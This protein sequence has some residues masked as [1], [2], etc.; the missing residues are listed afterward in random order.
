MLKKSESKRFIEGVRDWVEEILRWSFRML[1][2]TAPG[3]FGGD[4]DS[5]AVV[6]AIRKAMETL[7]KE[8]RSMMATILEDNGKSME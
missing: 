3:E 7:E 6:G 1:N 2:T 5:K 8:R 4:E